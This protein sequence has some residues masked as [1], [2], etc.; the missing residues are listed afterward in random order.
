M[1]A[2][3]NKDSPIREM[4]GAIV[5]G[6][7]NFIKNP[8][9]PEKPTKIWKQEPTMMEPCSYIQADRTRFHTLTLSVG[10]Y[11]I[12]KLLIFFCRLLSIINHDSE[13]YI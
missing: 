6:P 9:R 10:R 5:S 3:S 12:I 1:P 7:M 4:V 13:K 11:Y 2:E 8:M